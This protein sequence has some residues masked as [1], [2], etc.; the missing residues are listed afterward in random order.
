MG[1]T[2]HTPNFSIP[3]TVSKGKTVYLGDFAIKVSDCGY[4]KDQPF[5]NAQYDIAITNQ[6]QRDKRLF[7]A[8]MQ[9]IHPNSVVARIMKPSKLRLIM[10]E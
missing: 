8:Q 3:F 5:T 1:A 10:S 7:I 4:A 9:N 6:W 2:F